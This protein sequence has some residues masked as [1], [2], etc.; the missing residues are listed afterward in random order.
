MQIRFWLDLNPLAFLFTAEKTL[1]SPS[2]KALV[3]LD[4]AKLIMPS[5]WLRMLFAAATIG[6]NK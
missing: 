4:S 5:R 2:I 6:L 3:I 1:L